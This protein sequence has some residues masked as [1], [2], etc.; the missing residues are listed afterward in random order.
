MGSVMVLSPFFSA[1]KE[2]A[3]Y[4]LYLES[5]F[6]KPEVVTKQT[7]VTTILDAVRKGLNKMLSNI[8]W[9]EKASVDEA[10]AKAEKV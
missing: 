9:L 2:V 3:Y 10:L 6:M 8:N 1:L 4:R 5:Q 7:N